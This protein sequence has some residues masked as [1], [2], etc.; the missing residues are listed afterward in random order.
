[1][2][3][4][5]WR[6]SNL[7]YH[8]SENKNWIKLETNVV[9]QQ[10]GNS[11]WSLLRSSGL[12]PRWNE[13]RSAV[14]TFKMRRESR[15]EVGRRAWLDADGALLN[16]TVIDISPSGAKLAID[17]ADLVPE[18]FKLRLTRYGHPRYPCRVVWRASNTIGVTF[19]LG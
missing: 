13:S 19:E 14:V 15:E 9:G 12:P 8:K 17:A 6:R 5:R 7:L 4:A 16:C 11:L 18:T 1:M 3:A 2:I 10:L